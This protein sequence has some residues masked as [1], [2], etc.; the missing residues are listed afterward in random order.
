M[1]TLVDSTC[2]SQTCGAYSSGCSTNANCVCFQMANGTGLCATNLVSY[3]NLSPC[4][5]NSSCTENN[6]VCVLNSCFGQPLCYPLDRASSSVCPPSN[7]S[8]SSSLRPTVT[9]IQTVTQTQTQTIT[10][11]Q[12]SR[13]VCFHGE[14][15]VLKEDGSICLMR[16]LAVGDRILVSRGYQLPPAWSTVLAVDVYQ[17]YNIKK[18]I[19]YLEIH[20][21]SLSS[22]LHITPMHSLLLK[23]HNH[24]QPRYAFAHEACVGDSVYIIN[25]GQTPEQVMITN[26]QPKVFYD[27]YAPLTFEG[28][29]VVNNA[30]VSAYGSF[31]HEVAH[32]L[33]KAPR[34]WWLRLCSILFQ[35]HAIERLD[36]F[37]LHMLTNI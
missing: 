20:T 6:T 28:N 36:N 25:H 24:T 33:I 3:A 12:P 35:T 14:T 18:P 19:E 32:Y 27:A 21:T 26:I 7:F 29:F 23:K 4:D 1:V 30:I 34:R 10:Q 31:Q 2:S 17:Y 22:I 37:F 13:R 8:A 5:E 16:N 11:A 15:T 9:V